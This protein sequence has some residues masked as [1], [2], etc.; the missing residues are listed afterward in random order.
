MGRPIFVLVSTFLFCIMGLLVGITIL[1][2]L[3]DDYRDHEG[4]ATVFMVIVPAL[5][6][7]IFGLF[8][9]MTAASYWSR[10][11]LGGK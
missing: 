5:G 7:A 8:L 1:W 2:G 6:G 9:G 10:P 3:P 11:P 4:V